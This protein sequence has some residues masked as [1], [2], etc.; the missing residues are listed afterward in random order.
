ME[1]QK[2]DGRTDG[3]EREGRR[4]RRMG[5]G[6]D[7]WADEGR[8]GGREGG[9]VVRRGKDRGREEREGE[10][11][12]L[13]EEERMERDKLHIYYLLHLMPLN[14]PFQCPVYLR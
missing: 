4:E 9:T 11:D 2:E 7:G 14:I 12:E 10:I 1:G 8:N 6:R 5:G 13:R 3:R